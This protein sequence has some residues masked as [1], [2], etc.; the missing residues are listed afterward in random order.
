VSCPNQN[1]CLLVCCLHKS[2]KCY[3]SYSAHAPAHKVI[4]LVEKNEA[5]NYKGQHHFCVQ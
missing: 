2:K 3:I 4:L 1:V 5:N